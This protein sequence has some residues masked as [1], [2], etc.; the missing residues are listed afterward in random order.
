MISIDTLQ[1]IS[2]LKYLWVLFAIF[3]LFAG[4][5]SFALFYHW[6]KYSQINTLIFRLFQ[7]IFLGGIIFLFFLS[8]DFFIKI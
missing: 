6:V 1:N 2:A 3:W 7:F 8:F 5:M 4:W